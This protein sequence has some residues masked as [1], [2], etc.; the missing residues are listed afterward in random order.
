MV[1]VKS[2]MTKLGEIFTSHLLTPGLVYTRA[3][4]KQ[5]FSIRDAT[6]NTGVFQPKGH[7]SVWLF[8]TEKKTMDRTQYLDR[9]EGDRLYWQ[10]QTSGRTD[11]LIQKHEAHG[12]ELLLFYRLRKTEHPGAGFRY[13][14]QFRYASHVG[15]NPAS[16]LLLRL[17]GLDSPSIQPV[18]VP[19]TLAVC[20]PTPTSLEQSPASNWVDVLAQLCAL[21][22]ISFADLRARLLPLDLLPNA[23]IDDINERALDLTGEMALLESGDYVEVQQAVLKHVITALGG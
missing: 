12:L 8:V 23:V 20:E 17:P 6:I 10:G 1:G 13:E 21:P 7:G 16:F 2:A 4:L 19:R 18:L 11:G 22:T 15:R 14:G 5:Q 9:L 3:D